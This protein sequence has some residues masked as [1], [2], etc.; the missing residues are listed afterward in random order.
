M[1]GASWFDD[2][3]TQFRFRML[4]P[5]LRRKLPDPLASPLLLAWALSPPLELLTEAI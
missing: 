2:Q 1:I 4:F 5:G 3:P